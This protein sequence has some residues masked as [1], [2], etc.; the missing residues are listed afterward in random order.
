[1]PSGSFLKVSDLISTSIPDAYVPSGAIADTPANRQALEGALLRM[2]VP[3]NATLVEQSLLRAGDHGFLAAVLKP[4]M[5]AVSLGVN[6]VTGVSGLIEPGDHVDVLMAE[7][8]SSTPADA[9]TAT[10][11]VQNVAKIILSNI[12][13]VAVG[14]SLSTH[15]KVGTEPAAIDQRAV[16]LELTP[17]QTGI[18]NVA[19]QM[20]Q[21]TLAVQSLTG[22]HNSLSTPPV[23]GHSVSAADTQP[24]QAG[25]NTV[26]IYNGTA[27][28]QDAHF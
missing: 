28:V 10:T 1:M 21:I 9:A 13:I 24:Q 22:E 14:G 18:L 11:A 26:H 19:Q 6:A 25:T 4:G 8:I 17:E 23:W 7:H 16:T 5:R 20:G 15:N 27:G 3:A 2:D 12:R